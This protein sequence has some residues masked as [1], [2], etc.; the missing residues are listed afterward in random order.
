MRLKYDDGL[1]IFFI[2]KSYCIIIKVDYFY[3][4]GFFVFCLFVG[5]DINIIIVYI[6]NYEC[7]NFFKYLK[8]E[9]WIVG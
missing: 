5:E 9:R 1:I 4:K 8:R 6:R 7:F 3:C 2:N